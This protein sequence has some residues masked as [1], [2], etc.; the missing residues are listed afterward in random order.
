MTDRP[1]TPAQWAAAGADPAAA[2]GLAHRILSARPVREL[3]VV[4]RGPCPDGCV[5]SDIVGYVTD[6]GDTVPVQ[7]EPDNRPRV[8]LAGDPLCRVCSMGVIDNPNA[9]WLDDVLTMLET[10]QVRLA[11]LLR[12]PAQ[13]P[14]GI[15]CEHPAGH[16]RVITDDAIYDHGAMVTSFREE[17]VDELEVHAWDGDHAKDDTTTGAADPRCPGIRD[18]PYGVAGVRFRCEL[19]DGHGYPAHLARWQN[20]L[21]ANRNPLGPPI[22]TLDRWLRSDQPNGAELPD[23]LPP[24][25]YP[26]ER[27]ETDA[28]LTGVHHG[29]GRVCGHHSR[30]GVFLIVNTEPPITDDD[31]AWGVCMRSHPTP[32]AIQARLRAGERPVTIP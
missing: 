28:V 7:E 29:D 12:C 24:S 2:I 6:T 23:W 20:P 1:I 9:P 14:S 30:R 3:G 13:S 25:A 27:P 17:L 4:R 26:D 15:R 11:D 8:R 31:K 19:P 22:M 10:A 32:A 5:W 18:E 16:D 21:D